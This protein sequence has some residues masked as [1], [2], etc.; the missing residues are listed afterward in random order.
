MSNR[1]LLLFMLILLLL[2]LL[3]RVVPLIAVSAR[4]ERSDDKRLLVGE[5]FFD[6]LRLEELPKVFISVKCW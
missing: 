3:F 4:L 2:M 6:C 1:V 5:V